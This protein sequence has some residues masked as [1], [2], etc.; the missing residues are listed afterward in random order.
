MTE[1]CTGRFDAITSIN[2]HVFIFKNKFVWRLD[3]NL[4]L[5]RGYPMTIRAQF[6]GIDADLEQMAQADGGDTG[7]S[8]GGNDGGPEWER[9][10]DAAY[11]RQTDGAVVLFAGHRYWT[12]NG[13]DF[14]LLSTSSSGG[15]G[16]KGSRVAVKSHTIWDLGLPENVTR[17]DAVFVWPKNQKTYLFAAE[18]FW[19]YDDQSQRMDPSGSYP[20]SMI[21]WHGIPFNVD[22]VTSF[23][24]VSESFAGG[25]TLF[26][27]GNSYWLFNDHWVRPE[28]GYPKL[29]SSLFN[30]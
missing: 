4:F 22:A 12:F 7:N 28:I 2:E 10:V 11:Q 21:R 20:R 25:Q 13:S 23:P 14:Q 27:K 3:A 29:I 30:C 24:R 18:S 6:P 19:K 9:I 5:V 26:F 8:G 17:I 16:G 15:A 1:L